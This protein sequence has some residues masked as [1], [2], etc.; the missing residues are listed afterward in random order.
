MADVQGRC[1][2]Q[3]SAVRRSFES[4][5]DHDL[6]VGA[7]VAV[8]VD[9]EMVVDLWGGY[10]DE[11]RTTPWERDTITN[12][13]SS[14]KTVTALCALILHDRGELDVDA[15]VARYWPEFA[16]NGKDGVL[17]RHLMSHTAG[18]SG[19]EEPI[20]FEDLCDWEK[21]T[22]LLAAQAPWWEPGSASGYHALTQG[23]LVGEV[24]RRVTGESLGTFLA[25]EVAGPVGAD[26]HV[27]LAP[28]HFGRVANVIPPPPLPI[29]EDPSE[30]LLKTFAN[31]VLNAE[32]AWTPEWRQAESP[33]VN[34]HGNARSLAQ[35]HSVLACGGEANRVRFVSPATCDTIFRQQA[36]GIDL[37]L[38]TPLRH[39]IGFGLVGEEAPLSPN[40]RTCY[41]GGWGG[42][43][44]VIDLDARMVVTYVMNR[45]GEGTTGDERGINLLTA[46]YASLAN[47]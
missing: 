39:G 6:D 14:T 2:E 9:G 21:A 45:M 16:A 23:Y 38:G 44:V 12:V 46:A 1:D 29:P 5:F 37:V 28:E 18:L 32:W 31:P 47:A 3:F 15:P 11:A 34:G 13:W 22:S 8:A 7:S 27:G 41:W 40:E 30:I 17:V 19:W 42:S 24:V 4:N 10:A 20:T 26:F 35:I 43:I 36:R 25:K 33:A